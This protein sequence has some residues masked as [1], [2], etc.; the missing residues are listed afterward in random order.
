MKNI[1]IGL[2]VIVFVIF[3]ILLSLIALYAS[4]DEKVH[5]TEASY[6]WIGNAIAILGLLIYFRKN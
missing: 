6:I 2:S 1:F 5:F 4:P 3:G